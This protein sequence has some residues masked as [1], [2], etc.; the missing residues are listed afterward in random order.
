MSWIESWAMGVGRVLQSGV[1]AARYALLREKEVVVIK[2][3]L[4]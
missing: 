3:Q 2:A 4:G 1:S